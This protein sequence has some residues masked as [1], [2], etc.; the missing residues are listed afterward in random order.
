MLMLNSMLLQV[1]HRSNSN[2][3]HCS[4]ARHQALKSNLGN[5]TK[6]EPRHEAGILI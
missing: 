1:E 2:S 5:Q 3:G 6:V 4:G